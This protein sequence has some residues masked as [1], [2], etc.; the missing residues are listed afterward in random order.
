MNKILISIAIF[1][2]FS[3]NAQ[4]FTNE[5]LE[6]EINLETNSLSVLLKEIQ[7][8]GNLIPIKYKYKNY[9]LIKGDNQH[10]LISFDN[11]KSKREPKIK[12]LIIL[13]GN[14]DK[15]VKYLKTN[16][17]KD[18]S[19]FFKYNY[20]F[21]ASKNKELN[22]I[23]KNKEYLEIQNKLK[24]KYNII[25]DLKSF[26]GKYYLKIL[27]SEGLDYS[28]LEYKAELYLSEVG[29]TFKSE[30]P[31]IMLLKGTHFIKEG[32]LPSK[33]GSFILTKGNS[34]R[35]LISLSINS[36]KEAGAFTFTE[37]GKTNT[38]TFIIE[39]FVN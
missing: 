35:N 9:Y 29:L 7:F 11:L 8:S 21:D 5:V 38:T 12:E 34:R 3:I 27:K 16:K 6:G 23:W 15:L 2:S 19:I 32:F 39:K 28:K 25:S 36:T 14:Y 26:E 10:L 20:M 30:I 18:D 37:Y 22:T 4:T 13:N 24:E 1:L 17:L 31:S 33:K